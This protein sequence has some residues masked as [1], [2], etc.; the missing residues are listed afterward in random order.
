M[1]P[2]L[3]ADFFALINELLAAGLEPELQVSALTCW[4]NLKWK[5][6]AGHTQARLLFSSHDCSPLT[7]RTSRQRFAKWFEDAKAEFHENAARALKVGDHMIWGSIYAEVTEIRVR[8][9]REPN[10]TPK[11]QQRTGVVVLDNKYVAK[12]GE[13]RKPDLLDEDD[14]KAL[15]WYMLNF[16]GHRHIVQVVPGAVRLR[17][18]RPGTTTRTKHLDLYVNS[19]QK[20]VEGHARGLSRWWAQA[21]KDCEEYARDQVEGDQA[22]ERA[23][24]R[25]FEER[26][27]GY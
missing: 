13:L 23:V 21:N 25:W 22:V 5:D 16:I 6:A 19:D 27:Y 12:A 15:A 26:G 7:A 10:G 9:I 17:W 11:A 3:K 14:F 4:G 24:E 20:L 1:K 18:A 2:M 8:T